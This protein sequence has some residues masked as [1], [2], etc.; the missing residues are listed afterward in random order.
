MNE[1][2]SGKK[3]VWS[4]FKLL[5]QHNHGL[6]KNTHQGLS[7]GQSASGRESNPLCPE[8]EATLN[9]SVLIFV[10]LV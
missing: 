1:R 3:E 10:G 5:S 9:T 7:Q 4:I 6:C 2:R 8:Y